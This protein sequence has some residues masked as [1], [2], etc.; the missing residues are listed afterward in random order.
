MNQSG[1]WYAEAVDW[2]VIR[3]LKHYR[4]LKNSADG[5]QG[6]ICHG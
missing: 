2:A 4:V 5:G 6:E 3:K 1:A